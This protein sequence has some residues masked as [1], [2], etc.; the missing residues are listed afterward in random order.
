[1]VKKIS[2]LI[3]LRIVQQVGRREE[4]EIYIYG[5]Q[6]L[7]NTIISIGA[8]LLMSIFFHT[9][10]ETV[11]FLVCYCSLRIYAGGLHASSNERCM[12]I[13]I[14]GYFIIQFVITHIQIH[15]G[16]YA[17][18]LLIGNAFLI[19][20]WAPIEA[21]NNPIPV[22]KRKEMKKN[23]FLISLI[24]LVVILIMV[25]LSIKA[26]IWGVA[27]V[28]WFDAIFTA[29]KFKNERTRRSEK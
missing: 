12:S 28:C 10:T 25:S 13:F 22:L 3:A 11:F 17:P 9:F 2:E 19:I 5:L 29:G 21:Y 1:M 4:Q 18:F 15:V 14:V 20:I 26:S 24:L 27:G 7:I 8:V 16:D 6:I 23:A